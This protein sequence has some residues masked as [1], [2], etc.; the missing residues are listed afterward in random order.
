VRH[1]WQKDS[2]FGERRHIWKSAAHVEKCATFKEGAA[3]LK[4]AEH[5]EKVRQ[6]L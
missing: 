6:I 5:L 2:T 4:N 3:H 1:I